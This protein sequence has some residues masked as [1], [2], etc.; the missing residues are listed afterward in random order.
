MHVDKRDT[1]ER[2]PVKGFKEFIMRGNVIELAVAVVIGGAFTAIVTA[3]VDGIF[4]PLIAAIFNADDISKATLAV[5]PVNFGIGLVI[6]A[7]IKFLLIAA[8][9]YFCLVLPMNKLQERAYLKKHGHPM[10]EAEVQPTE[11]DLLIEIRDL[12]AGRANNTPQA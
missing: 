7:V 11:A 12:L 2:R 4:N 6:A 10:A 3:L 1:I 5:G 8:V 9:V